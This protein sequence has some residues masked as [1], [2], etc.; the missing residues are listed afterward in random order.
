MKQNICVA[1]TVLLVFLSCPGYAQEKSIKEMAHEMR[2]KSQLEKSDQI[3][4]LMQSSDTEINFYGKVQNQYGQPV[5]AAEVLFNLHYFSL[6]EPYFEG[7]KKIA[8][9]TNAAGV[10]VLESLRG[11]GLYLAEIGSPGHLFNRSTNTWA[12]DYSG[13]RGKQKF[14]PDPRNPVIFILH[15]KPNPDFVVENSISYRERP[16]GGKFQVDVYKGFS[17][18]SRTRMETWGDVSVEIQ[19]VAQ[20]GDHTIQIKLNNQDDWLI[21]KDSGDDPVEDHA[22][23]DDGYGKLVEFMIKQ[24]SELT[25]DLYFKG[26]KETGTVYSRLHLKLSAGNACVYVDGGLYTNLDGGKNLNY[27]RKYTLNR[28]IQDVSARID[29]EPGNALLYKERAE[30]KRELSLYDDAIAD[31]DKALKITPENKGLQRLKERTQTNKKRHA[32][33]KAQGFKFSD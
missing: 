33:L 29:K 1:F 19:P 28:K 25:K 6:T 12:F 30:F 26:Q 22:A 24:H 15:K 14:V 16:E 4:S 31:I 13:R 20:T 21:A 9:H 8:T 11:N 2:V 27:D 3:K 10:F 5:E 23:P 7:S 32:E 17:R 18:S